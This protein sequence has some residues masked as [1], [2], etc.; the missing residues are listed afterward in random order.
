MLPATVAEPE[1]LRTFWQ[2]WLQWSAGVGIDYSIGRKIAASLD[3]LGL[4]EA[5]GEG[6]TPLFNGG[7]PW[8]SYWI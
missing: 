5:A 2:G 1:P 7:S 3:S 6:H 8:A 4:Q